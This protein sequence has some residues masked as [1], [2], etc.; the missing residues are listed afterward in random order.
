MG[1][2]KEGMQDPVQKITAAFDDI[3]GIY[4]YRR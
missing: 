1:Q 4:A 3:V 2:R